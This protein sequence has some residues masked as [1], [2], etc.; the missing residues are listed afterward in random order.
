MKKLLLTQAP[1]NKWLVNRKA[2]KKEVRIPP[3]WTQFAKSP[4]RVNVAYSRAQNL[5]IVL[6]N[7]WGWNGVWVKITRDN[8]ERE[9][10][11]Y[12]RQLMKNT[13]RG[14]MLDGRDLL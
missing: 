12:Y 11:P 7:R 2:T 14:G 3:P 4:N 13:I 5:L 9:E 8:G 1:S 6:G 10:F